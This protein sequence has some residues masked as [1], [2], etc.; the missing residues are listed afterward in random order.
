[1]SA[2]KATVDVVSPAETGIAANHPRDI[3]DGRPLASA[4]PIRW[5]VSPK[6]DLTF[7]IGSCVLTFVFFGIYRI[8]HNFGF[9][10]KG[11]S[12]LI[13]YFLFT[14]FFDHP[15]IFQTF[16]RTHLDKEEFAKRKG[17]YT[18][19]L[20]GF[21][22]VGYIF[23]FLKWE[24]YLIV[25][26]AIY[27]SWHIIRQHWGFI[28]I[29][30]GLNDDRSPLDNWIDG[31][32]YF[33]GMFACFLTDY[34]DTRGSLIIYGDIKVPVPNLP[35]DWGEALW[36]VFL[37]FASLV[38][39]RQVWR[40]GTGKRVNLPK[41]LLMGAAL[42]THY[43][44]FFITATPFLIAEALETAYHDVQYQGWMMHYQRKRFPDIKKVVVKWAVV[45][46]LYGIIVGIIEING[47]LKPNSWAMWLFI[48]FTM[49]VVWHYYVDGLIWRMSDY[50]ELRKVLLPRPGEKP[51]GEPETAVPAET[52]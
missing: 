34:G 19:G 14:A 28:K 49:V 20:A 11:D 38:V 35:G 27:G 32:A 6:Y 29:Y 1:M 46:L 33:T 40:A 24:A 41:L 13:T 30:K 25:G 16:S 23:L 44:I 31:I 50:P 51:T 15:H 17:L 8:A 45:G 37:I 18:W 47:L 5:I 21:I 3:S 48:P 43:Y 2:T 22:L 4:P 10:L 12:I 42:T 9:V 7:F 39:L 52:R 26:A 36:A